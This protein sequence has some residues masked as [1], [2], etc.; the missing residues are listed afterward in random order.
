MQVKTEMNC[1]FKVREKFCHLG[2]YQLSLSVA[3]GIV[4]E[5]KD[6]YNDCY[7]QTTEQDHKYSTNVVHPQGICLALLALLIACASVTRILPPFV[8]QHLNLSSLLQL[9]NC[10]RDLVSPWW[11]YQNTR[12]WGT[13]Q[14]LQSYITIHILYFHSNSRNYFQTYIGFQKVRFPA[15]MEQIFF[16]V[17]KRKVIFH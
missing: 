17:Y 11:T 1:I 9:Q 2:T 8:I 13:L 6:G 16:L 5:F 12:R 10:Q 4:A 15:K 7:S 3:F 14:I